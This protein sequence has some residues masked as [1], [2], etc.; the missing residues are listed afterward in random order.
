MGRRAVGR[1]LVQ[2]AE[3]ALAGGAQALRKH[4]DQLHQ[5]LR[6]EERLL[7]DDARERLAVEHRDHHRADRGAGGKA[8]LAVDHRHL[9]EAA[10]GFH[11][12][13]E[14]RGVP[15][16]ALVHVA[17]AFDHD[18]H[19]VAGVTFAQDLHRVAGA[20][21]VHE[22][23]EQAYLG[24]REILEQGALWDKRM[25][26]RREV[27]RVAEVLQMGK[28][29]AAGHWRADYASAPR[30]TWSRGAGAPLAPASRG[31]RPNRPSRGRDR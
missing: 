23:R 20:V 10:A 31:A 6:A 30:T 11:R 16:V 1:M 17:L 19:E 26:L 25:D 21:Y 3:Q 8:R 13:E 14:L 29:R 24:V 4:E 12:G 9:A 7:E 18:Q 2:H 15:A 27:R 28:L 5:D 22:L